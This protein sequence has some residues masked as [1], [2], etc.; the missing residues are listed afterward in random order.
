VSPYDRRYEDLDEVW[1]DR[2]FKWYAD[3]TDHPGRT[4]LTWAVTIIAFVL[5]L[6]LIG[7]LTGIANVYW[8][9]EKAK[10]TAPARVTQS[11]YGTDNV[12]HNVSYFHD[13][14][15]TI[16]AD[17]QNVVNARATLKQDQAAF[18]AIPA[19]NPIAQQQAASS[20]QQDQVN[21]V[22]AKDQLSNDVRDYDS[23]SATQ[24]ANPFKAHNLPYRISLNPVTG[25]LAGPINCH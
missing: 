14:C 6:G 19:S 17:Q 5:I 20:L 16:L 12:L 7:Q 8:G 15:N 3:F 11:T 23:K 13:Q 22:G 2:T 18:N 4:I 1:D 9:A 24:T 25:E 21:L 10:I